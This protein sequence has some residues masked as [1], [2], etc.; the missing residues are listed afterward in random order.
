MTINYKIGE[1]ECDIQS[2]WTTYNNVKVTVDWV[3]HGNYAIHYEDMAH[4]DNVKNTPEK[5]DVRTQAY[6]LWE[7]AGCPEGQED[8][9]WYK[10]KKKKYAPLESDVFQI[11]KIDT[12]EISWDR[13][14]KTIYISMESEFFDE[15]ID[16]FEK[17]PT[18]SYKWQE[19]FKPSW[20]GLVPPRGM[21]IGTYKITTYRNENWLVIHQ[22]S[23]GFGNPHTQ[24]K[25]M[26][27]GIDDFKKI[28]DI[29]KCEGDR[30]YHC[31]T[32][33]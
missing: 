23:G 11:P 33:G 12:S 18:R 17:T 1:I 30:P 15:I 27:I 31:V 26:I 25:E 19:T 21:M 10:A 5:E 13:F 24:I 29:I 32:L 6:L 14:L 16:A 3:S 7:A 9:F 2:G 4:K 22:Q 8:E 28:R 20:E